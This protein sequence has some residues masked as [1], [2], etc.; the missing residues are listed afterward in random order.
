MKNVAIIIPSYKKKL[1]RNE[2]IS[3]CQCR[4]VLGNYDRYFLVPEDMKADYIT[5]EIIV[6][7]DG[8]HLSSRKQYSDYMLSE[9]FYSLFSSYQYILIYQLDAFVFED[10]LEY[11]CKLDYDYIGAEWLYGLECHTEHNNLWYWGNGGFSLRKVS[12]FSKWIAECRDVVDYARMLLPEDLAISIFG[13]E[14]LKI[15]KRDVA[16]EFSYDMYPMEC[17]RMNNNNLPFGCHAWTRFDVPFWKEIIDSY[18]YDVELKNVCDDE[19]LLLCSGKERAEKMNRYFSKDK[20]H[21][22]MSTLLSKWND[23]L[24]VFGAGQ[25]GFSFVNM[26]KDTNIRIKAIIDNDPEKIGKKIEGKKIISLESALEYSNIPILITLAN[27]QAVETLLINNGLKKGM[28]YALSSDLQNEM[29]RDE[30]EKQ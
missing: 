29:C 20:I 13:A 23:E 15:A 30:R 1:A 8:K 4:K 6:R 16:M 24:F 28:D 21:Y 25:Y 19:T 3:L 9:N 7:I 27:P 11:F 26:V 10:R 2:T 18:G 14:T 12:A 17:Y 22:C 5:D